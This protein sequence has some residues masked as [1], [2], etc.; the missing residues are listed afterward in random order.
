MHRKEW[1]RL[2]MLNVLRGNMEL[3]GLRG[4]MGYRVTHTELVFFLLL[5]TRADL[6][7]L[8]MFLRQ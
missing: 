2:D 1:N 6:T 4:R 3:A 8:D 7:G 5:F